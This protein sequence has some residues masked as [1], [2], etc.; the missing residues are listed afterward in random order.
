MKAKA[1]TESEKITMKSVWD[2]GDGVRLSH[3][4]DR[5]NEKYDRNWKPQTVST[6]L[7]KL[8]N[9]G[10]LKQY[11]DGR[12]YYYHILIDKHTYRTQ[13]LKEDMVFW[14]D[15]NMEEYCSELLDP[16]TFTQEEREILRDKI[17]G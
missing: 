16:K 12:Y 17:N 3:V 1:L 10:Y 14:D 6:F 15:N 11:R 9:K 4:M 5:V 7:G 13:M 8:V 2:L